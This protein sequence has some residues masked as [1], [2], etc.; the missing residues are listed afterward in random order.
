MSSL[1]DILNTGRYALNVQQLAMQVVGQNTANV[2]TDGYSRRRLELTIAPPFGSSSDPWQTGGGV[3]VLSLGRVRDTLLDQQIRNSSRDLGY[4]T[5]K[6]DTL[7]KVEDVFNELGDSAISTQLQDFWA[8]WQDLA[9]APEGTAGRIAVLEKA[10][11]LT[12]GV[13]RAY[14]ELSTQRSNADKQIV[15]DVNQVNTLTSNIA[16]LNVQ[17]VHMEVGGQEASDL[18]DARDNALDQLSSLIDIN[19]QE[20]ADGSVNVYNGG[21]CL[22]QLDHSMSLTMNTVASNGITTTVVQYGTSGQSLSLQGGEIKGL[23]ELR[24]QDIG[25]VMSDLDSFAVA[26][27]NRVNEVHRTGYGMNNATGNDFFASNVTGAADFCVSNAVANDASLIA[28]GATPDASG[29]NSIA[30]QIAGIQSEKLLNNGLSTA[31]DF[32]RDSILKLGSKKS[33]AA[34]Q[35][36]VEQAAM[37]NL[38]NRRQQVSGVS[39]DEEMTRLVQVQQAYNAAAKIV[40]TVD[41]MMQTIMAIGSTA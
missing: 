29:D 35:L 11:A 7:G 1:S 27:A 28:T 10:Q 2:N 12:A 40:T 23:M 16:A 9:N 33:Y 34:G 17:I 8:S 30:L 24:D 3:D 5:Q 37:D 19:T 4:W 36:K 13:R 31:D 18:R 26:L 41:E 20:A 21:R 32:Y 15:A 6:D 39:L 25:S 38:D 22:V 14:S